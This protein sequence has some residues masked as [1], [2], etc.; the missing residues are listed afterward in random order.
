MVIRNLLHRGTTTAKLWAAFF[1]GGVSDFT[2]ASHSG[3]GIGSASRWIT[4][5]YN[6]CRFFSLPRQYL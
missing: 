1:A 5:V 2:P 3:A 6:C 4:S